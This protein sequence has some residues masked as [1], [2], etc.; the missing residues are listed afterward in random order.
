MDFQQQQQP[1]GY[2]GPQYNPPSSVNHQQLTAELLKN[3]SEISARNNSLL[4]AVNYAD[5]YSREGFFNKIFQSMTGN[6]RERFGYGN[7]DL[8]TI[9]SM[10]NSS[11]ADFKFQQYSDVPFLSGRKTVERSLSIAC[12]KNAVDSLNSL[13]VSSMTSGDFRTANHALEIIDRIN[14]VNVYEKLDHRTMQYLL[15]NV[16]ENAAHG[17][18]YE[19]FNRRAIQ[20]IVKSAEDT[21][22]DGFSHILSVLKGAFYHPLIDLSKAIFSQN[23]F[24]TISMQ[25]YEGMKMSDQERVR[26]SF[27]QQGALFAQIV[28]SLPASSGLGLMKLAKAGLISGFNINVVNAT[29]ELSGNIAGSFGVTSNEKMLN[30]R[31]GS[32]LGLVAGTTL[33]TNARKLFNYGYERYNASNDTS[34]VLGKSKNITSKNIG[35]GGEGVVLQKTTP[36]NPRPFNNN[37]ISGSV[38]RSLPPFKTKTQGFGSVNTTNSPNNYPY[39][40]SIA[41]DIIVASESVPGF[42][43]IANEIDGAVSSL[44]INP[45]LQDSIP[46]AI[47]RRISDG[48]IISPYVYSLD[49]KYIEKSTYIMSVRPDV[50][51]TF[52]AVADKSNKV[53]LETINY[54][55]DPSLTYRSFADY[56]SPKIS[57]D[58]SIDILKRKFAD[59]YIDADDIANNYMM[60]L[61]PKYVSH[62]ISNIQNIVDSSIKQIERSHVGAKDTASVESKTISS[63]RAV[64]NRLKTLG[65][66][67]DGKELDAGEKLD[68]GDGSRINLAR[69]IREARTALRDMRRDLREPS[70]TGSRKATEGNL[71]S[72]SLIQVSDNMYQLFGDQAYNE[73]STID[74]NYAEYIDGG[75]SSFALRDALNQATDNN[76]VVKKMSRK[77]IN[78][79][80]FDKLVDHRNYI[81]MEGSQEALNNF[82][83]SIMNIA[84]SYIIQEYATFKGEDAILKPYTSIKML[85]DPFVV[86]CMRVLGKSIDELEQI[87]ELQTAKN[88]AYKPFDNKPSTA[89]KAYSLIKNTFGSVGELANTLLSS[90]VADTVSKISTPSTPE[91]V[92]AIIIAMT[93][94]GDE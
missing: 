22:K 53:M 61:S 40:R 56:E 74:A 46:S 91:E 45:V 84:S 52:E 81:L 67:I 75:R 73:I 83:D 23:I 48:H 25:E 17:V 51:G 38:D 72:N 16:A 28:A 55:I 5:S 29:S 8:K 87:V 34:G 85:K 92:K 64:I 1:L 54:A 78:S 7:E 44:G 50:M 65:K 9:N 14:S 88:N 37:V 13:Y 27:M 15:L 11:K 21:E 2:T 77:S 10:L 93:K 4:Q 90:E 43:K 58:N 79:I 30:K 24:D 19:G 76:N 60:Q 47:V 63:S 89:N 6:T 57:L 18:A 41:S 66:I 80:N 94:M 71:I 32:A 39:F 59:K 31:T 69:S 68:I 42:T 86:G 62:L 33:A 35:D 20:S 49:P 3:Y 36:F 26:A 12:M 70:P 82:D